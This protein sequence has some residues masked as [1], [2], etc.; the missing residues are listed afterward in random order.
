[1]KMAKRPVIYMAVDAADMAIADV[2]LAHLQHTGYNC[3]DCMDVPDLL[4]PTTDLHGTMSDCDVIVLIDSYAFRQQVPNYELQ[5][6]QQLYKPLIVISLNQKVDE[7][8]STWHVRLFDFTNP[9]RRDWHRLIDTIIAVT[10]DATT[11]PDFG[12]LF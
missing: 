5:Y 8:K 7:S 3:I 1:M 12:F 4:D 10:T 2:I 9:H 6:A 11:E